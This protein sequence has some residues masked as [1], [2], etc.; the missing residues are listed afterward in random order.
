MTGEPH[1]Q[2]VYVHL[3]VGEVPDPY[4]TAA[5]DDDPDPYGTYIIDPERVL[6]R[7]DP[8]QPLVLPAADEHLSPAAARELFADA[9]DAGHEVRLLI[10]PS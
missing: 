4:V 10:P 6:S 2:V 7:L 5:T 9:L 8:G 3:A 1:P